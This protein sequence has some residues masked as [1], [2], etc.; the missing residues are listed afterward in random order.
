MPDLSLEEMGSSV[1]NNLSVS[2]TYLGTQPRTYLIEID[3]NGTSNGNDTFR[4]SIDG[5]ANFNDSEIEISAG[6]CSSP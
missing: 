3:G 4:W 2:G 5:G 6:D 1:A